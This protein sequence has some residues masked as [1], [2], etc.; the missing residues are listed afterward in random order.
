MPAVWILEAAVVHARTTDESRKSG[1]GPMFAPLG[2][3]KGNF[4]NL[5]SI[6]SRDAGF[7]YN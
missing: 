2:V 5:R 1:Y 7:S 4:V 3:C 6:L